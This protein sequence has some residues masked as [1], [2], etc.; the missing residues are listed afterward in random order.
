MWCSLSVR[1][2]GLRVI[3]AGVAMVSRS[4]ASTTRVLVV[5]ML[6]VTIWWLGGSYFTYQLGI[7]KTITLQLDFREALCKSRNV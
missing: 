4:A 5:I 6:P 1:A 2:Q 3:G 7:C